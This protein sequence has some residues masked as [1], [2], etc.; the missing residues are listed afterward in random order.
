MRSKVEIEVRFRD[1]RSG[2]VIAAL[3]RAGSADV[4]QSQTSGLTGI[5]EAV[6]ATILINALGNLIAKLAAIWQCGVLVD[7]RKEKI[8][9]KKDCDLPRGTVVVIRPDK[10]EVTIDRPKESDLKSII[11]AALAK[12]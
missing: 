2:K 12:T 6:I 7:A 10:T 11:E 4:K 5:E 1:E 3:E 9:A 8:T